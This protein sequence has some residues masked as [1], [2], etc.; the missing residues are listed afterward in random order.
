MGYA[1]VFEEADLRQAGKNK[2]VTSPR[3]IRSWS[4]TGLYFSLR[5]QFGIRKSP[6]FTLVF[7]V[8]LYLQAI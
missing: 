7:V 8:S 1:S 2:N 6:Y 3:E 4:I 5:P